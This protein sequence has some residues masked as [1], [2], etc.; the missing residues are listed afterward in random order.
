[1]PFQ[2]LSEFPPHTANNACCAC[3]SDRRPTDRLFDLGFS[4]DMLVDNN[5]TFT[6]QEG[7]A[8]LCETCLRELCNMAGWG[9]EDTSRE[10]T[11]LR[12]EVAALR[13]DKARLELI[14]D[15]VNAAIG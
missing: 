15:S 13:D 11:A 7:Y 3:R 5:G 12:G 1:M 6:V 4:I 8:V 2:L 14:V 9:T 10:L